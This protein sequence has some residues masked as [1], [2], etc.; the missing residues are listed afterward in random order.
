MNGNVAYLL[1]ICPIF[2]EV[3][4]TW[5]PGS[6]WILWHTLVPGRRMTGYSSLMREKSGKLVKAVGDSWV[7]ERRTMAFLTPF[8][9]IPLCNNDIHGCMSWLVKENPEPRNHMVF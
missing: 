8:Y 3:G 9:D 7:S 1:H 5:Q 2:A 6:L 4:S